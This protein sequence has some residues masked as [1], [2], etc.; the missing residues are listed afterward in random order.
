MKTEIPLPASL[1]RSADR[2]AA[3][4]GI[5]RGELYAKAVEDFVNHRDPSSTTECLNEIYAEHPETL[6]RDLQAAQTAL[7]DD[8]GW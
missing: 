6:P 8:E 3:R 5:S 7:L 2:L 1:I 4:M